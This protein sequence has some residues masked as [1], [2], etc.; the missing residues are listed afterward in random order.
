MFGLY[1]IGTREGLV[2][3]WSNYNVVG[4]EST[5]N[6]LLVSIT[7]LSGSQWYACFVYG[8]PRAQD[9]SQVWDQLQQLLATYTNC[10][11]IGNLIN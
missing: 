2:L 7:E 6:A 11:I 1:A 5:Q 9:R 8:V 3:G 4:I 10:I